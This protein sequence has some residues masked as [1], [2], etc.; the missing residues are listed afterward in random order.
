MKDAWVVLVVLVAALGVILVVT[1]AV[2]TKDAP[3]LRD[4]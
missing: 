3:W 2:L 4:E 1:D